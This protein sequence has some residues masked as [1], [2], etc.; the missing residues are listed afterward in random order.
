MDLVE[1]VVG[2]SKGFSAGP[3]AEVGKLAYIWSGFTPLEKIGIL[4]GA[5]EVSVV[6]ETVVDKEMVD[7]VGG[8]ILEGVGPVW[9]V[10][11]THVR[12]RR[13]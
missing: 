1:V 4:R 6:V 3:L 7:L 11:W 10:T 8:D 5:A 2:G 13:G 12:R 9:C